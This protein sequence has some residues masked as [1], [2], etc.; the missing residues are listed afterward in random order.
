MQTGHL[1]EIRLKAGGDQQECEVNTSQWTE[2]TRN[3]RLADRLKQNHRVKTGREPSE[4]KHMNVTF[5]STCRDLTCLH[6]TSD[7]RCGF[8]VELWL[9]SRMWS[10]SAA[11]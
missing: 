4:Q 2:S 5:A 10:L 8:P 7:A 11:A 9:R 3:S 6:T 1:E